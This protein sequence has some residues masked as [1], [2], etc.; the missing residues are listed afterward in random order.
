MAWRIYAPLKNSWKI[1][2]EEFRKFLKHL[3]L[4]VKG[5]YRKIIRRD[6][7]ALSFNPLPNTAKTSNFSTVIPISILNGDF[8][9][10]LLLRTN[11]R[12]AYQLFPRVRVI[13]VIV[14][15]FFC[16]SAMLWR[17]V[18]EW[19]Y[20]LIDG[21]YTVCCHR[22]LTKSC[23][24]IEVASSSEKLIAL[25]KFT[26]FYKQIQQNRIPYTKSNRKII[27]LI[28][29]SA[30]GWRLVFSSILQQFYST[31]NRKIDLFSLDW[32]LNGSQLW[33]G[34]CRLDV[35]EVC[36]ANAIRGPQWELP[37]EFNFWVYHLS[38]VTALCEALL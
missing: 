34:I 11:K 31:P 12:V 22:L 28:I 3:T 13:K 17:Y 10:V 4:R 35:L 25:Y 7:Y 26:R 27:S 8:H 37:G 14:T 29:M 21:C 18:R 23:L 1:L 36:E 5:M 38:K 32:W 19:R 9:M 20:V 16:F 33:P 6:N 15:L 30:L 2:K 24:E